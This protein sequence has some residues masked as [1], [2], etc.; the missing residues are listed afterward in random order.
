MWKRFGSPRDRHPG[1][2]V[3]GI[4]SYAYFIVDQSLHLYDDHIKP[5]PFACMIVGCRLKK[6]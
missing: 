3:D 5:V 2:L 4:P 1:E 6:R